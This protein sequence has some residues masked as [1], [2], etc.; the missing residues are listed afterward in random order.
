G[1]RS[2]ALTRIAGARTL[3]E[4]LA[5]VRRLDQAIPERG[6]PHPVVGHDDVRGLGVHTGRPLVDAGDHTGVPGD[7]NRLLVQDDAIPDRQIVVPVELIQNVATQRPSSSESLAAPWP[8]TRSSHPRRPA[9][10]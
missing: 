9:S 4:L 1:T 10:G 8:D 2:A 5:Q 7:E 6:H 3:L